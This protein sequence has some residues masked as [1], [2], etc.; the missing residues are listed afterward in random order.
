MIPVPSRVR[1]RFVHQSHR[2]AAAS[3]AVNL[4]PLGLIGA[5]RR[6]GERLVG[7]KG[8]NRRPNTGDLHRF[9]LNF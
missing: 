9:S 2:W 7:G 3:Q 1:L 4:M 5:F 6:D 8:D